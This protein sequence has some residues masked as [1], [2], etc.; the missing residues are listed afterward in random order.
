METKKDREMVCKE[1][2]DWDYKLSKCYGVKFNGTAV[3]VIAY[4]LP[5]VF[6]IAA[7]IILLIAL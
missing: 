2:I 7:M 5:R 3:D 6:I 1:I 4:V